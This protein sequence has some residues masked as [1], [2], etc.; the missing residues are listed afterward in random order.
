M[1]SV[2]PM[3]GYLYFEDVKHT[4]PVLKADVS[5]PLF[6]TLQDDEAW[7]F[8]ILKWLVVHANGALQTI[9]A[10]LSL[11]MILGQVGCTLSSTTTAVAAARTLGRC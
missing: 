2:V 5:S 10:S 11:G 8:V 4:I 1:F 7:A 9:K 3:L 6:E